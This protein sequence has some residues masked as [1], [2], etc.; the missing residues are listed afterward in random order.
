MTTY[1]NATLNSVRCPNKCG[2]E[3]MEQETTKD[4]D[5]F[6]NAE[7]Y[8]DGCGWNA[9][10]HPHQ[11]LVVLHNPADYVGELANYLD[12]YAQTGKEYIKIIKQIIK[13]NSLKDFDDAKILPSSIQLKSLI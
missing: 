10:W 6:S 7:F 4:V 3:L 8:C 11:N 9:L 12:K 1:K 5:I 13:Q 2:H